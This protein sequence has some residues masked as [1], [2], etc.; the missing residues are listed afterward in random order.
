MQVG[1]EQAAYT[2][3]TPLPWP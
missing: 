3:Q 1:I 2:A